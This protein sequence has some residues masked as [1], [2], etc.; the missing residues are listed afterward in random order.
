MGSDFQAGLPCREEVTL[1]GEGP[2]GPQRF[3]KGPVVLFSLE[4]GHHRQD[5]QKGAPGSPSPSLEGL[6][7]KPHTG[8]PGSRTVP[9]PTWDSKQTLG[10]FVTVCG[11][12]PQSGQ[13]SLMTWDSEPRQ[14]PGFPK[15]MAG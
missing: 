5:G 3:A 8:P 9:L 2:V 15:G 7:S 11:F 14:G 12:Y 6:A 13:H 4:M 1:G 10:R